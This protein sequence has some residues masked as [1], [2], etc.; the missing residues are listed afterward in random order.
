MRIMGICCEAVW[1]EFVRTKEANGRW[2]VEKVGGGGEEGSRG[3][4]EEV[5][6]GDEGKGRRCWNRS[7]L[8]VSP[9][10]L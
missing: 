4:G 1:P 3:A 7:D 9:E 5:D 8:G 6:S 10:Q 2:R